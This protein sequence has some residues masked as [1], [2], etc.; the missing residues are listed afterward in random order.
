[1]STNF[2][3][4]DFC[5]ISSVSFFFFFQV[6]EKHFLTSDFVT[7]ST[8][9]DE[10]TGRVL[11]VP[12]QLRRLKSGAKPSLFPNCPSYLSRPTTV[13]REGP[14]EKRL[15]LE[16]ESLQEAIRQS[17]EAH[18]EE[19]KKNNISTFED[20]LTA[21]TSFQTN[22]FWTKLVTHDKLPKLRFSRS[23]NRAVFCDSVS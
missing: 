14:E 12:L 1:M 16:G 6:C 17:V 11:E 7:T 3:L 21:L 8:Y 5:A 10:K 23:S 13:V 20:L 15:R 18:E 22:T 19:K 4:L 9:R 2:F